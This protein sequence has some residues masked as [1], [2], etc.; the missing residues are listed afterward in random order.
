MR[1]RKPISSLWLAVWFAGLTALPGCG[2]STAV[3]ES[4]WSFLS[5]FFS[6]SSSLEQNQAPWRLTLQ[7]LSEAQ[8]LDAGSIEESRPAASSASSPTTTVAFKLRLQSQDPA[9]RIADLLQTQAPAYSSEQAQNALF[10]HMAE[11]GYLQLADKDV[12]PVTAYVEMTTQREQYLD[13]VFVFSLARPALEQASTVRL[14]LDKA[15]FLS[16]P[17]EFTLPAAQLLSAS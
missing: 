13:I 12:R 2:N 9:L 3:A 8:L 1:V 4:K 16:Q 14:V 11:A 17:V 6:K 7:S 15:F 10:Y 5:A